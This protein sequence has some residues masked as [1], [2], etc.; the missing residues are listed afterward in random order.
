MKISAVLLAVLV[1]LSAST[2]AQAQIATSSKS[3][4]TPTYR[5]SVVPDDACSKI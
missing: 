2:V 3:N 4:Q 5:A 1:G